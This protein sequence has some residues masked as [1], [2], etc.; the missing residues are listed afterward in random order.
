MCT[1]TLVDIHKYCGSNLPG[2]KAV[3]TA[4]ADEVTIPAADANT[5]T[6]S[7]DITMSGSATFKKWS[8]AKLTSKHSEEQIVETGGVKGTVSMK[9]KGDDDT[10]RHMFTEM[11]NGEFVVMIEDGNGVKKVIPSSEFERN[12]DTGEGETDFHGYDAR[13]V[14]SGEPAYIYTGSI[15]LP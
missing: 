11:A 9:F 14:Y 3:Y 6:I 5:R 1:V 4:N 13:F 12:Y 10:K 15:P 2:L 8:F 7:A